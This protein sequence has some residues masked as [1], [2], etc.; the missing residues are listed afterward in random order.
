MKDWTLDDVDWA[1]FEPAKVDREIVKA[2]KAA[3][4]VER[5]GLDYG[6]YLDNVFADDAEFRALA[7]KWSREEVQHGLALGRWA[8]LADPSFDFDGAFARFRDGYRLETDVAQSIRGS[9]AGE[10]M[11]RC[12]VETGTSSYYAALRDAAEEPVLKQISAFIAADELRHYKLFYSHMR[13]YLASEKLGRWDRVRI[14][15]RRIGESE[16]DELAC[17]FW[18][19]NAPADEP[20]DRRRNTRAYAR[21]AYGFY[22]APH[23]ERGVAMGLKAMGL[24]PQGRLNAL[25]SRGALGFLRWRADRLARAGA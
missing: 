25:V 6:A 14:G 11:A 21:R 3:A 18:A 19:A 20:Y 24:E 2:V 8:A 12:I 22:R 1:R 9:R 13:R 5:N 10:L 23:V 7:A 17:A 4:L 16:D 15:L